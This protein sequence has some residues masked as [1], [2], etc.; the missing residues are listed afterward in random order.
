MAVF[1]RHRASFCVILK[2]IG[3]NF[4]RGEKNDKAYLPL[5]VFPKFGLKINI[6]QM[7]DTCWKDALE[8]LDHIFRNFSRLSLQLFQKIYIL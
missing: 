6:F 8:C 4:F 7:L 2:R 3:D 1:C 5:V